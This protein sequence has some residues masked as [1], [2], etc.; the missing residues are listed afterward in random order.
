MLPTPTPT[1]PFSSTTKNTYRFRLVG[2]LLLL[3]LNSWK[4]SIV[5]R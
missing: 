4:H 2:R 5:R 3:Q 1:N